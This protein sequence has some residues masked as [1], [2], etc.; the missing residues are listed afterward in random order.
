MS[1]SSSVGKVASAFITRKGAG[2][3]FAPSGAGAAAAKALA[4]AAKQKT[5]ELPPTVFSMGPDRTVHFLLDPE[6]TNNALSLME[7]SMQPGD[8]T[9]MHSHVTEDEFFYFVK[10]QFKVIVGPDVLDVGPGDSAF[11]PRGTVHGWINMSDAPG[12]MLIGF[13]PS[14]KG[15]LL[16]PLVQTPKFKELTPEQMRDDYDFVIHGPPLTKDSPLL[17]SGYRGG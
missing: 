7:E 6:D 3:I 4:A 13:T 5:E 2:K 10:G 1:A 14:A 16:L 9:P 15:H 11:V 12:K 8:S 17:V